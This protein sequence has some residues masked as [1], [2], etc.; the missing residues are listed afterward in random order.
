MK[1]AVTK[2]DLSDER[3]L[4]TKQLLERLPLTRVSLWRMAREGRFIQPIRLTR[5]RI[6]WRWSAV[7]AW[8]AER[9]THPVEQR[10]YFG[11][12]PNKNKPAA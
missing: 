4:T 1:L 10:A 5:S 12:D 3:I 2:P 7:L 9:E 6:G 11:A 8:L